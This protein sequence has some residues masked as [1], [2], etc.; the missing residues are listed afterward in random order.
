MAEKPN[1]VVFMTDHQR[2]DTMKEGSPV[3]TPNIDRFRRQSVHFT[4][5]YCPAPHCCPSRATF[6]SGLY[7]SEHGV[8][9]NVNVGNT[10][11][12]GLFENTRLFSQDLQEAG[13]HL[14]FSGKWHVSDEQGPQDFGF[15][16][17]YHPAGYHKSPRRPDTREWDIYYSGRFPLDTGKEP[18]TPGRI[19]RPGYPEYIQYGVNESPF[20][21]AQVAQAAAE[22]LQQLEDPFFL[23]VGPLGPH[24]PYFVPQRFLDLYPLESISLPDNFEDPMEDKPALYRRTKD[25]YNQLTPEEHR[26][27]IRHFYAFCS[28]EDYLFGKVLEQVEQSGKIDNTLILYVSDHGDYVGAHGLWAK[29]LPCFREA[30]HVCSMIGEG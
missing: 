6:F 19:V 3:K 17:L 15:E 28:Y 11:S 26:E 8:W 30:Y 22:K 20:D 7:P 18:H 16:L 12:R 13:Y 23:Y 9:N 4:R 5:A 24:D 21:D 1:I 29:G 10:L 2:G 14:F 25:R 27:S